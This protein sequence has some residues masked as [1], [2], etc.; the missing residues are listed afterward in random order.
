[1]IYLAGPMS[2]YVDSNY[3]AFDTAARDLRALGHLVLSPAEHAE[4]ADS[5]EGWMRLG[6]AQLIQCDTIA[7]L[8]GWRDSRGALV[9][10][11]LARALDM[12]VIFLPDEPRLLEEPVRGQL[13][14]DGR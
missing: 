7:L 2:D 9:E 11:G 1:M 10:W 3:P 8:P 5:W 12:R 14:E 6:I 13:R 4:T